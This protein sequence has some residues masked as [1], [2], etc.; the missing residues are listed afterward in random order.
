ME[1]KYMY[2]D[3]AE[4]FVS[5]N[6]LVYLNSLKLFLHLSVWYNCPLSEQYL[7]TSSIKFNGTGMNIENWLSF[8]Q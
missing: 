2:F 7:L 1:I 3:F 4:S 6:I 8:E 5:L